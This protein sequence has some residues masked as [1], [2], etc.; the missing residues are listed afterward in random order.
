MTNYGS[1]SAIP[2]NGADS[3]GSSAV[4]ILRVQDGLRE[5]AHRFR[6]DLGEPFSD[7]FP[8]LKEIELHSTTQ[9]VG[10]MTESEHASVLE[11]FQPF[12]VGQEQ[13]GRPVKVIWKLHELSVG[14]EAKTL[15]HAN[16]R[17]GKMGK[18]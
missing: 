18:V 11:A 17:A 13:A 4:R 15:R 7:P 3:L 9:S 2:S 5:I 16:A 14:S 12:F 10:N 6:L 8:G 1:S